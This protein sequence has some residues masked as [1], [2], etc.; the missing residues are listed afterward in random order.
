MCLLCI[1]CNLITSSKSE[2]KTHVFFLN[3][4]K[5]DTVYFNKINKWECVCDQSKK[6]TANIFQI[7][8]CKMSIPKVEMLLTEIQSLW[9]SKVHSTLSLS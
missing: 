3:Y 7:K 5:L 9:N 6:R 8:F 2:W 4:K 1:L